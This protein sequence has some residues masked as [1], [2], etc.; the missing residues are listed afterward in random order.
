METKFKRVVLK[1]SGEA[2]S[3]NVGHGVDPTTLEYYAKEIKSISDLGVQ[4][5][6]VIGGGNIWRGEGKGKEHMDQAQSHFMGMLAT[7]INTL[8]LQDALEQLKVPTRA[9]TAIQMESLAEPY[10]RRKAIRHLEKG[11]V[12]ILGGGTGNPFFTT[13][14]AAA[15]RTAEIHADVL[16]MAKNGV[17]GVYTADP[18][19]D[20]S[21][22]KLD[23][24][25]YL[26]AINA[27]LRIMDSTAL[28]FA[29]EHNLPIVVF[30]I[31]EAGN[32]LKIISGEKIGSLISK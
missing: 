14:S 25:D 9:M 3:G 17:D 27:N 20:S 2:L 28:T 26:H 8:A 5:A 13:D 31:S 10:I 19:L 1:M 21:A 23:T 18:K 6:V 11:R 30:N 24:L 12:V 7:V 4:I 16:L 32:L 29:N 22:T 15:I